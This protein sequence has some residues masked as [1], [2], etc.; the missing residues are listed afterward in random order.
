MIIKKK[1]EELKV[2]ELTVEE[3]K[4]LSNLLKSF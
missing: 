4:D 2:E 1:F 3:F